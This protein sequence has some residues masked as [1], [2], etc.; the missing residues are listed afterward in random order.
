MADSPQP[1]PT[2]SLRSC[3]R[4]RKAPASEQT[5]EALLAPKVLPTRLETAPAA[6]VAL[7]KMSRKVTSR[8]TP[9]FV[10]SVGPKMV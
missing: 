1:H 3:R 10:F 2:N 5:P 4:Y 8:G 6:P 7:P 9:R